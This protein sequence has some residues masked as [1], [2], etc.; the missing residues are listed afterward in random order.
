[1]IE[2]QNVTLSIPKTLRRANVIAVEQETSLSNLMPKLLI[3]SIETQDRHA[4]ACARHLAWLEHPADLGTH[5]TATWT[6]EEL[7]ER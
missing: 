3:D 6:R 1:M 5:G 7:Y 4:Q 2:R